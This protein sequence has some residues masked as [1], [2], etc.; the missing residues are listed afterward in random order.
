MLSSVEHENSFITSR[1]HVQNVCSK[2]IMN[3]LTPPA[4]TNTQKP[5]MAA[6][7]R[8]VFVC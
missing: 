4:I 8:R 7:A 3:M 1:P 5:N 2:T 6:G